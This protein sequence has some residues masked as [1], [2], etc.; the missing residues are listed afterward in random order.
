V[1]VGCHGSKMLVVS[2]LH[3]SKMLVLVASLWHLVM[4]LE[5]LGQYEDCFALSI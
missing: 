3:G 2:L 4:Y 1:R 5:T